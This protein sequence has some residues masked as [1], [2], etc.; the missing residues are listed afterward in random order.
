VLQTE[1]GK[2]MLVSFVASNAKAANWPVR[3]GLLALGFAGLWALANW[4]LGQRKATA[5]AA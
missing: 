1:V 4:M 3:I 2:P 5:V